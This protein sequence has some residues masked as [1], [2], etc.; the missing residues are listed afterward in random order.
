[1]SVVT[2]GDVRIGSLTV[3]ELAVYLNGAGNVEVAGQVVEQ[4]VFFNG[5]GVYRAAKL[6]SQRAV[7]EVN[8]AGS[9]TLW[10]TDTLDVR[11]SGAGNVEYYGDPEV[12]KNISIVGR[13]VSLDN[14]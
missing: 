8:G 9:V 1:M 10:V 2:A 6:E 12:T 5:F 14:P 7:V 4:G 3:E 11:I 13:L